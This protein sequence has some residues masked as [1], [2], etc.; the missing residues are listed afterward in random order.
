MAPVCPDGAACAVAGVGP[1]VIA[2]AIA[3]APAATA[4][5]FIARR[6]TIRPPPPVDD[7]VTWTL[8]VASTTSL[9]ERRPVRIS[10]QGELELYGGRTVKPLISGRILPSP[11]KSWGW[12]PPK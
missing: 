2:A 8:L 7:M 5:R 3:S 11:R 10:R 1:T 12:R 4:N 9:P 6:T